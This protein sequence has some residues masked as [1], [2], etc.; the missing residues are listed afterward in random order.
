MFLPGKSH[1][2]RSLEGCGPWGHK[3]LDTTEQQ[4]QPPILHFW[5][6]KSDWFFLSS[7]WISCLWTRWM[8]AHCVLCLQ[9]LP[10][11]DWPVYFKTL[12]RGTW[13]RSGHLSWLVLVLKNLRALWWETRPVMWPGPSPPWTLWPAWGLH[14]SL[15][16]FRLQFPVSFL[17]LESPVASQIR[18]QQGWRFAETE[19]PPG[20]KLVAKS[21]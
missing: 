6:G 10:L 16:S 13:T 15:K 7:Q 5:G 12:T 1:G 11:R 19:C 8:D 14:E 17:S 9:S 21:P 2:Q 20:G 3:K 18:S 4:Q